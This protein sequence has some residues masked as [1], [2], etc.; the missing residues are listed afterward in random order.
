[1]STY[2][3][4]TFLGAAF[5]LL[6][7]SSAFAD[8]VEFVGSDSEVKAT[9]SL[10][11]DPGHSGLPAS[12]CDYEFSGKNKGGLIDLRLVSVH[13]GPL[14]DG[15]NVAGLQRLS[16]YPRSA[17]EILAVF[18]GDAGALQRVPSQYVGSWDN[19]ASQIKIPLPPGSRSKLSGTLTI[20][21][22]VI[23]Q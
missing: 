2:R 23:V 10:Y 14:C 13:G 1:M 16:V 11:F 5:W 3:A 9:G 8:N 22:P 7:S 12:T 21:P 6:A 18:S 15:R 19:A 17:N 20:D 4:L